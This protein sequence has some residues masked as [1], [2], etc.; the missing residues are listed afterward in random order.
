MKEF[1]P[2]ELSGFSGRDGAPAYVSYEG[3]VYDVSGSKLWKSGT[4]MMK[5][6]A[7]RVLDGQMA[8]APHGPEVLERVP[9]VGI[10]KAPA[11]LEKPEKAEAVFLSRL[12]DRHPFLKRHPH[13]I[14]VHFP[15]AFI[16]GAFV[17]EAVF[18]L[19]G[20]ASFRT[21]SVHCLGLGFL[22]LPFAIGT[23]YLTWIVN[24]LTR[25]MRPVNIKIR[26]SWP[27]FILGMI[28]LVWQMNA[29][30]DRGSLYLLSLF[31]LSA[32]VSVIGYYG[33]QLTI[34]L[35]KD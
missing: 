35:D 7:G 31:I 24:Y 3:K 27:L 2:E 30:S 23:G 16:L 28:V 22:S 15:I 14:V 32:L 19:T 17:L 18:A 25:P 5:H 9:R 33:G 34:P 21:S 8:A 1:K 13:P 29:G 20:F 10:L 11:E 12:L 26:L 4:H 6:N